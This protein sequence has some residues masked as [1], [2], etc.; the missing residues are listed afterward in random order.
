MISKEDAINE[1][2]KRFHNTENQKVLEIIDYIKSM[3][4]WDPKKEDSKDIFG[5]F[6]HNNNIKSLEDLIKYV[7]GELDKDNSLIEK[8]KEPKELDK[9]KDNSLIEEPKELDDLNLS[10]LH[11]KEFL[12]EIER[13]EGNIAK[14]KD[15][16]GNLKLRIDN[17]KHKENET[18]DTNLLEIK[19][20]NTKL[21]NLKLNEL[22]RLE[23]E[24]NIK[25]TNLKIQEHELILTQIKIIQLEEPDY[26]IDFEETELDL[27]KPLGQTVK[28][29]DIYLAELLD[30]ILKNKNNRDPRSRINGFKNFTLE[31][32]ETIKELEITDKRIE[33]INQLEYC[34]NLKSLEIS[35]NINRVPSDLNLGEKVNRMKE[36]SPIKDFSV[37]NKLKNLQYLSISFQESLSEVDIKK[38]EHLKTLE[39]YYNTN[40]MDLTKLDEIK[41][42]A[43][44]VLY[45]NAKTIPFNLPKM[46]KEGNLEN[47]ELD[48][49]IYE[50]IK[51]NQPEFPTMIV[52]KRLSDIEN[53]NIKAD[54][55]LDKELNIGEDEQ[56]TQSDEDLIVLITKN[57]ALTNEEKVAM[58]VICGIEGEK[59]NRELIEDLKNKIARAL[60][61]QER[62]KQQKLEQQKEKDEDPQKD[63]P[64]D[65]YFDRQRVIEPF[66]N[67]PGSGNNDDE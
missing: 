47:V 25:E 44:L 37:I 15:E 8:S 35:S 67:N 34:I 45:G 17:L 56:Y 28:I 29:E 40:L 19:D 23:T 54:T 36:S 24:Y 42:L 32:L 66:F 31:E 27:D 13:R 57:S 55:E 9:D 16:L 53:N 59:V 1:L 4:E 60:E 18:K 48:M 65:D 51:N 61:E 5:E 50:D 14:L 6:L 33:N 64:E 30:N 22:E 26:Q 7:E 63:Q 3:E 41:N 11:L 46:L 12:E 52:E 2:K 62:L 49:S 58:A 21:D 43:K 38:L 20:S 10:E 39:L